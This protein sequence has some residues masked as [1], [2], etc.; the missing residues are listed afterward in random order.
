[1]LTFAALSGLSSCERCQTCEL[2][3][4]CA[5][6]EDV[7]GQQVQL[8]SQNYTSMNAYQFAKLEY[9]SCVESRNADITKDVCAK[10]F[11]A[12]SKVDDD[13]GKLENQGYTCVSKK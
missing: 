12:G 7:F 10:G 11:K 6:C 2:P 4:Y 3:S 13:A 8:C 1:M 9:F 5:T